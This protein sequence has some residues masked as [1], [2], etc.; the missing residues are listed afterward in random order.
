[1]NHGERFKDL[2]TRIAR[3]VDRENVL[4]HMKTL[5]VPNSQLTS[6]GHGYEISLAILGAHYQVKNQEQIGKVKLTRGSEKLL[7]AIQEF[8]ND[9]LEENAEQKSELKK[10]MHKLLGDL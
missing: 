1:M 3:T 2:T 4:N 8:F 5:A 10:S 7:A 9:Q 6:G